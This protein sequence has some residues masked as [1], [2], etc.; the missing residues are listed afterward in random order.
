MDATGTE[1]AASGGTVTGRTHTRTVDEND[2]G[3]HHEKLHQL[4]IRCLTVRH[5]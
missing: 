3:C 5:A 4:M 2:I 1:H